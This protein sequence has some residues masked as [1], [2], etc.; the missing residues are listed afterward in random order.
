A[1]IGFEEATPRTLAATT[2][3][4]TMCMNAAPKEPGGVGHGPEKPKGTPRTVGADLKSS[5]AEAAAASLK[6]LEGQQKAGRFGFAGQDDPGITALAL[7]AVI[8]T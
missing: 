6:Y 4:L 5:Y 2:R 1:P 8:R 3:A 7:D